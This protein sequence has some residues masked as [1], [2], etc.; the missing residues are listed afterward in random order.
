MLHFKTRLFVFKKT[1]PGDCDAQSG[2][3]IS[4]MK[5]IKMTRTQTLAS[6]A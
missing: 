4:V 1:F 2:L 3:G 5:A 6:G